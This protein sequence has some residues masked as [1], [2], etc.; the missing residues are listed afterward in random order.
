MI[1]N[2][3]VSFLEE[4]LRESIMIHDSPELFDS[5]HYTHKITSLILTNGKRRDIRLLCILR[6]VN[7]DNPV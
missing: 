3:F 6:G 1:T 7:S 2:F 4:N 5:S